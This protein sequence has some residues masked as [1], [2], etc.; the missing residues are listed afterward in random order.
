M[1]L[2]VM[3]IQDY[4]EVLA[5]WKGVNGF[6][7]R[8]IDDSYDGMQKF[9]AKNPKTNV[10]AICDN[11]IV[12]S[13]LCGYDGRCA[14]LYH[15]CVQKEYRHKQIGKR[16]VSFVKD[17]LQEEGATHINLV[18]FKDNSLGNLFWQEIGWQ[19]KDTMNL[20]ECI[21]DSTNTRTLNK[22]GN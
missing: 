18:A 2:R 20:Y 22:N 21:L 7:I 17:R 3:T 13:I 5:L 11:K 14:Y 15:V 9:L 19:L 1:E 4:N 6:Y 16:M 12:G 10:I 8:S